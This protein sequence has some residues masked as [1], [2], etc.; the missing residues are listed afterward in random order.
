MLKCWLK[1]I[2]SRT[3]PS[4]S[5]ELGSLNSAPAT[6][7][8]SAGDAL[9]KGGKAALK[10]GPSTLTCRAALVNEALLLASA[11]L[12]RQSCCCSGHGAS[13]V[14]CT[15]RE[16]GTAGRERGARTEKQRVR[17]RERERAPIA[18]GRQRAGRERA[19]GG[20]ARNESRLPERQR[21]CRTQGRALRMR[22]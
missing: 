22:S 2:Q 17:E 3:P 14:A 10:K 20:G 5:R 8:K 11:L 21:A 15:E 7:W 13:D 6:S 16:G 12:R 1:R 19:A 18:E 4:S 9:L